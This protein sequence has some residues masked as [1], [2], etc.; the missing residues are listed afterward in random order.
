[1]DEYT[2]LLKLTKASQ[3]CWGK[4]QSFIER[5]RESPLQ[6]L[7]SDPLTAMR[8]ASARRWSADRHAKGIEEAAKEWDEL[9]SA[10]DWVGMAVGIK[11]PPISIDGTTYQTAHEAGRRLADAVLRRSDNAIG[12][13]DT[14][15][16]VDLAEQ[17]ADFPAMPDYWA[18]LEGESYA[19]GKLA[20]VDDESPTSDATQ[21]DRPQWDENTESR[22]KWLYE[23]CCK[24]TPYK[25]IIGSLKQRSDWEPL[26][27]AAAIK[28]AANAYANRNSLP[29]IPRRQSGRPAN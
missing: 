29:A 5:F 20:P 9:L 4:S 21:N 1:M 7:S 14:E 8:Q 2:R 28:R 23:E 15:W 17:L 25:K 26:D 13:T 19:A 6:F 18:R 27:S 3:A 22:N 12:D 24:V 10:L 16:L 11:L